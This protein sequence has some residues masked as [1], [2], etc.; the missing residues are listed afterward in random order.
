MSFVNYY[1][2]YF[3]LLNLFRIFSVPIQERISV[4]HVGVGTPI[5]IYIVVLKLA[6]KKIHVHEVKYTEE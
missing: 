1:Y 6:G 2:H 4:N 3:Q 5:I